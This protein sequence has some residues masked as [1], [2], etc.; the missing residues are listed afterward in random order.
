[1]FT[2]VLVVVAV[3]ASWFAL[4]LLGVARVNLEGGATP[5][6][7]HPVNFLRGSSKA[8]I[9][10]AVIASALAAWAASR[11]V[12]STF[13]KIQTGLLCLPL[14]SLV[15]VLLN[16]V[17]RAR[18]ERASQE[19]LAE[20]RKHVQ[21]RRGASALPKELETREPSK[22]DIEWIR[23]ALRVHYVAWIV[24]SFVPPVVGILPYVL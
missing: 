19:V 15:V 10:F 17:R 3:A 8:A 6:G 22:S 11:G 1:M 23:K 14:L 2:I 9:V 12:S 7:P 16:A 13:L 20:M 21:R 24:L 5:Y 18:A 4:L